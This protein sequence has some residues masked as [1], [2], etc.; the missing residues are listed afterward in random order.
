MKNTAHISPQTVWNAYRALHRYV[1]AGCVVGGAPIPKRISEKPVAGP[2][3]QA[4]SDLA[5]ITTQ[6]YNW[7]TPLQVSS[8]YFVYLYLFAQLLRCSYKHD[9]MYVEGKGWQRL[10]WFPLHVLKGRDGAKNQASPAQRF[11]FGWLFR[12][13]IKRESESDLQYKYPWF[14]DDL[15]ASL[16]AVHWQTEKLSKLAQLHKVLPHEI[17][18]LFTAT[19]TPAEQTCSWHPM[20]IL[21]TMHAWVPY[22][23]KFGETFG[24]IKHKYTYPY[25]TALLKSRRL[26]NIYRDEFL[27][28]ANP[29]K[30]KYKQCLEIIQ[31]GLEDTILKN[32]TQHTKNWYKFQERVFG[33]KRYDTD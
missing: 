2:H 25:L 20:L 10:G 15:S 30:Q 31:D 12:E 21:S 9:P 19:G 17:L 22:A 32:Y 4:C 13:G 6:L 8:Q 24:N 33:T 26:A 18:F 27:P 7:D 16:Q 14:E 11:W 23:K 28:A 5:K 3:R 29:N 1:A